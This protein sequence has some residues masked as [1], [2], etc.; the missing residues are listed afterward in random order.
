M[1]IELF[2]RAEVQATP[3]AVERVGWLAN[4]RPSF[5]NWVLETLHWRLVPSGSAITFAGDDDGGIFC[6]ARGQVTFHAS[7]GGSLVTSYFGHPGSWWGMAPLLG[8]ARAGTVTA[9]TECMIGILP[10]RVL[11]T[12]LAEHPV[13]WAEIARA[14]SDQFAMAAGAHADLLIENS[15]NR[16]A[17]TLLRL[18]SNRH[19]CFPLQLPTRFECTQDE[20]ARATG[21]S[22]NTAG[23]HLRTL[24]R[25]GLIRIGYGQ[26]ELL[27]T[28]ALTA[29]AN[30]D[31]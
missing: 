29:L 31:S 7:L 22:R 10:L 14:V 26:I 27:D 8:L 2:D 9:R 21:L 15:R 4:C 16:V 5:R 3:D 20:L 6:L 30:A 28:R 12:R 1:R 19:R 18:G 13:D 11:R 23:V 25:A 17:A 24:E